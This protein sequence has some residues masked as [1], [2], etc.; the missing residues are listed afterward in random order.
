MAPPPEKKKRTS[1]KKAKRGSVVWDGYFDEL[2]DNKAKC[3]RCGEII[4]TPDGSTSNLHKH[5]ESYHA[6]DYKEMLEHDAEKKEKKKEDREIVQEAIA[7]H[8][9]SGYRTRSLVKRKLV[10]T[11]LKDPSSSDE[12]PTEQK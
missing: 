3:T 8:E 5:Y 2:E 12:L 9:A 1:S 6:K 7:G 11:G 10:L 4:K